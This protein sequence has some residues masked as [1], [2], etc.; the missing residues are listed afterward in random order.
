MSM[1]HVLV[2]GPRFCG[3]SSIIN[4]FLTGRGLSPIDL[5]HCSM[6]CMVLGVRH[7]ANETTAK[8]VLTGNTPVKNLHSFIQVNFHQKQGTVTFPA[9]LTRVFITLKNLLLQV[10]YM[11]HRKAR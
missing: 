3:K 4:N 7:S 10:P 8:L 9:T 1:K 5:Y 11:D 6:L 2:T